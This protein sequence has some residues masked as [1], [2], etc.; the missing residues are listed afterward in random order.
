MLFIKLKVFL[1]DLLLN[2]PSTEKILKAL[3]MERSGKKP[4]EVEIERK[5]VSKV[6]KHER[7]NEERESDN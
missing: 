7:R 1:F 4:L 5:G 2:S 3:K 6:Q